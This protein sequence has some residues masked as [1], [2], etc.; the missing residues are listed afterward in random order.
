MDASRRVVLFEG[1][2]GLLWTLFGLGNGGFDGLR[3]A[4]WLAVLA[5]VATVALVSADEQRFTHWDGYRRGAL[6]IASVVAATV[7]VGAV[8]V[9]TTIPVQTA[10]SIALVGIGL[11]LLVYRLVYGVVRPV[12]RAR[13]DRAGDR[14]V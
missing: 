6:A 3:E 2:M 8:V 7:L 9:A 4:W 5:G 11:G 13:L 1:G 12:P 10:V 14:A